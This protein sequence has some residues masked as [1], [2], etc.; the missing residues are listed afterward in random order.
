MLHLPPAHH[1]TSKRN[2]PHDTKIKVKQLK[3]P[4]FK[5]K[6]QQV[7]DSSQSNQGTHHLVSHPPWLV[8]RA[9][10]AR[11]VGYRKL[12]RE[13]LHDLDDDRYPF[14][15]LMMVE[16]GHRKRSMGRRLG[17]LLKMVGAASGVV[18]A[19]VVV[20]TMG[21]PPPGSNLTREALIQRVDGVSSGNLRQLG[22]EWQ[23]CRV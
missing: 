2:S 13:H 16:M 5:F 7:N 1:E 20:V 6:P 12:N 3:C 17:R 8:A 18:S 22:F 10:L 15:S 11:A 14:F 4:R 9:A 23:R 19:S 21:G